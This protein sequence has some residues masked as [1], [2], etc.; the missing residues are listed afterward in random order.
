MSAWKNACRLPASC[1]ARRSPSG[2][3]F[4]L[5]LLVASAHAPVARAQLNALTPTFAS[6]NGAAVWGSLGFATG[7]ARTADDRAQTRWGFAAF[8]GPFGGRGDTLVTFTQTVSDSADTTVSDASGPGSRRVRQRAH[9]T[10][11]L[12]GDTKR[13]GGGKVTLLVGYQHSSFYRFGT[14]PFRQAVPVGGAFVAALLGPYP[15]PLAPRRLAWYGGVGGTV[16]RLSDLATRADTLAVALSTER[17]FAP[18]GILMLTYNVA[19]SYRVYLG[20][21]YQYL[22]F[23]SLA[24]RAVQPGDRIPA[25]VLGTL[26][27]QL[28]LQSLHFSLGFSFT[29]NGLLPG[30]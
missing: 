20:T 6:L 23:G 28:E 10:H 18:E 21:S 2:A 25:T 22:R 4:L 5:L 8:Y 3:V 13:L 17:T 12:R 1:C 29:A 27:Q 30:R 9:T 19:P 7:G 11:Q 26:P 16:V 15:L 24:W 14:P